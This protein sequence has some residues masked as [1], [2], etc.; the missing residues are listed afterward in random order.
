MH[1][2]LLFPLTLKTFVCIITVVI[3]LSKIYFHI[4]VNNAF[5]SWE[6]IYMI[7]NGE[8]IDIR[9]IESAIA[10]DPKKRTGVILAKSPKAKAMGVKTGEAIFEAKRKCPN[11][12]LYPPHHDFYSKKSLEMK[13][14]L[15][16]Y[17]DVIEQFSIDEFFIEYVPLFGTYMEVA[18]KIQQDILKSLGFTVNIGISDTKYL[19]KVASDFEKPNKIHTL[20]KSEIKEKLWP[21]KI[22]DMFLLGPKSAKKLREIGIDTVGKLANT[23]VEILKTHLKSH[24]EEL[25]NFAWGYDMDEK[26]EKKD[27]PKSVSHSKTSVYDLTNLDE[28]YNFILDIV[29]DTCIRLRH[30]N[31]KTKNISVTLKTNDFN[32]YSSSVTL[33]V[34][35]DSTSEIFKICKKIFNNMYKHEPLR[36][37]GVNLS[38]LENSSSTQLNM[39]D[40]INEKTCIVDK[41]VDSLLEKFDNNGLITRGSL[42]KSK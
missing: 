39:F 10:G 38:C 35:I 9:N 29:N 28:I 33:D 21:L 3:E 1:F 18:K 15:E 17:S 31:M 27:T 14:L 12:K 22:Q 2:L 13:K 26:H 11:I 30:E 5:L 24:G 19:A 23:N 8:K 37:I 6:A 34:A 25:Y 32:T 40:T 36:L 4:D 16:N 41:T 20:F 7:Q 42:I